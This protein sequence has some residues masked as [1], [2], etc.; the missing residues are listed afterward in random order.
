[1]DG[2][3]AKWIVMENVPG[4]RDLGNGPA[5]KEITR[6]LAELGY[7]VE[8]RLLK[9]EEYGV[10][11]ETRRIFLLLLDQMNQFCGQS[12]LMVLAE[13]HSCPSGMP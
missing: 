6:S 12:Q 11:Q 5:I 13:N 8:R 3:G 1:V 7:R 9:A 10:P 4:M 2:L